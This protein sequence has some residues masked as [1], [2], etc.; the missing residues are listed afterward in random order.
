MWK[1]ETDTNV[2]EGFYS[3]KHNILMAGINWYSN[4]ACDGAYG[5]ALSLSDCFG[6]VGGRLVSRV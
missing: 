6:G 4:V 5:N 1:G 2:L 3:C